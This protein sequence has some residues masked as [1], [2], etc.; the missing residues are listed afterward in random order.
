MPK[1]TPFFHGVTTNIF[2]YLY[3]CVYQKKKNGPLHF[4][5]STLPRVPDEM[6]I[7][8]DEDEMRVCLKHIADFDAD[9][10]QEFD[11]QPAP[12]KGCTVKSYMGNIY[13]GIVVSEAT[14]VGKVVGWF[15]TA[16]DGDDSPQRCIPLHPVGGEQN[17][18]WVEACEKYDEKLN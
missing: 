6:P 15:L 12:V 10:L 14:K 16:I 5:L 7:L 11:P 2:C 17:E 3:F 18:D 8:D 1:I 13:S 4:G 9:Q